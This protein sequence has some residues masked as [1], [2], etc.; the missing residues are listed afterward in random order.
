MSKRQSGV[1]DAVRPRYNG[2]SLDD[3]RALRRERLV[4]ASVDL[5]GEHGYR[6]VT[7]RMICQRAGLTER[8]FYEAF[9]TSEEILVVAARMLA[10]RTLEYMRHLSVTTAGDREAKTTRMLKGYY[11]LQLDEP[12]KA[13]VFTLEFRGVSA[14]A[15]SEFERILDLFADLIVETRD[16]K[17]R[18]RAA[19]DALVRRGLVGGVLAITLAW[20]EGGYREHIDSVVQAATYLCGIAD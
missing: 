17:R 10:H 1:G 5:Y 19:N 2:V 3:R 14:S 9:A 18:G 15:D 12:S 20:I 7:V 8:Y 6:N 16:P 13:R 4:S 11:R